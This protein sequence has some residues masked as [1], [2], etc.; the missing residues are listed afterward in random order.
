MGVMLSF[1]YK[2]HNVPSGE[3]FSAMDHDPGVKISG[4]FVSL[5]YVPW[6]QG[7]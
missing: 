1:L 3:G 6:L 5:T 4:K 2:K 7:F